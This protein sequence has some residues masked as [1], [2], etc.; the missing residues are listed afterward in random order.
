[1]GPYVARRVLVGT[2]TVFLISLISFVVITLPPG[3][4]GSALEQQLIR[5]G[6]MS[7]EEAA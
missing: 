7:R 4:F 5:I 2:F 3:D 6:G 1:M